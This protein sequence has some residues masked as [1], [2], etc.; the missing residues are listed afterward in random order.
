MTHNLKAF[1][2][3][4]RDPREGHGRFVTSQTIVAD[5]GLMRL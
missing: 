3:L 2:T 5:D 1:A 4:G